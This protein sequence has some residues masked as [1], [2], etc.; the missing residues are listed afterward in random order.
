M[1]HHLMQTT[2]TTTAE[3]CQRCGHPI[4]RGEQ[5][6]LVPVCKGRQ[7]PQ[8]DDSGVWSVV[9]LRCC[10]ACAVNYGTGADPL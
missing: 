7:D 2:Q 8:S 3:R 6:A 5:V 10:D 1:T 9:R 4:A